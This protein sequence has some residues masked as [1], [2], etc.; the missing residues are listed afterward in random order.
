MTSV[1]DDRAMESYI[2]DV[3]KKANFKYGKHPFNSMS[4]QDQDRTVAEC[5]EQGIPLD[6]WCE[7]KRSGKLK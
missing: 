3:L 4:Q 6:E 7:M 5:K 1:D 2:Y